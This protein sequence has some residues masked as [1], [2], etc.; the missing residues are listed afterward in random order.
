M[1]RQKHP[2]M[3][4]HDVS[5]RVDGAIARDIARN[6][7]QRWNHHK[8]DLSS[9]AN[10]LLPK[11]R[12]PYSCGSHT[13]QL[14]RSLGDWSAGLGTIPECSIYNG[15]I[16]A[17]QSARKYIYIENQ[18]FVSSLSNEIVKNQIA[19]CIVD[20]IIEAIENKRAFKVIILIPQHPEGP[21][22]EESAA[23]AMIIQQQYRSISRG[24]N[25]ILEQLKSRYPDINTED[26]IGF[27]TVRN[28]GK[29]DDKYIHE[30]I[31]VH[32]KTL[33][34]DDRIAIIGSA[35]INDRSMLGVRDSEIGVKILGG[36]MIHTKMN[37]ENWKAVK[38]VHELRESLWRE[39]LGYLNN[40]E[41]SLSDP[42]NAIDFYWRPI[43]K[44]NTEIK[45][46]LFPLIEK[47]QEDSSVSLIKQETEYVD[48][49]P[50][51]EEDMNKIQGHL[52]E[53]DLEYCGHVDLDIEGLDTIADIFL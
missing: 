18:F 51:T 5:I 27:F 23:S 29:L 8:E 16:H 26:Y 52:L 48:I 49:T 20:K 47:E 11:S 42:I 21:H 28:F 14:L 22:Y 46:K 1:N 43:A 25:S 2:R 17:I 38:L 9:P 40:S 32:S 34:V 24:G 33:I 41:I 19:Q 15:Y 36:E 44:K 50:E 7:I 4:W 37:N 30:Q 3:P 35:N 45:Y 10:Y 12:K 53:F 6:F 39:H 13:I 31:Y